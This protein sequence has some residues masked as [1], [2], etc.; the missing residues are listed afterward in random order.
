MTTSA[1]P[2]DAV[3]RAVEVPVPP[4]RAFEVFTAGIA[5]WW[6]LATHSVYRLR[7]ASV[8]VEPGV[9]GRIVERGEDGATCVWGTV[10]VWD[11]G[12]EIAFSWH[13]GTPPAEATDVHVRFRPV[14]GGTRVVLV[15]TGW[16]ARPDGDRARGAYTSG[17]VPVLDRF[18]AAAGGERHESATGG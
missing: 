16:D 9:G 13:P 2:R 17:W 4:D 14:D 10:R 3:E 8:H 15:H 12:A 18:A 11:P 6:P 5:D 7:A 1:G